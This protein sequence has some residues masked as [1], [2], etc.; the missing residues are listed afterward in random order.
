MKIQD[1]KMNKSKT[2]KANFTL[3]EIVVIKCPMCDTT[4][5]TCDF[6]DNLFD[7]KI[8]TQV[9]CNAR[10]DQ[11]ICYECWNNLTEDE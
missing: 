3:P 4:I 9:A 1:D 2:I 11:H 6:C 7:G 8:E 5:S 10:K